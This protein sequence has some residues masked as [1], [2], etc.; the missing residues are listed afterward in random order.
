[1]CYS[2]KYFGLSAGSGF[3]ELMAGMLDLKHSPLAD[4]GFHSYEP[5]KALAT[6]TVRKILSICK[7][8]LIIIFL[9]H[10]M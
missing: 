4:T 5:V 8:V 3:L 10:P 1:M 9:V 2:W 7:T 6:K